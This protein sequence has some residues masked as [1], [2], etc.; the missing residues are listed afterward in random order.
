[1]HRTQ[2]MLEVWQYE[3]LRARA[4]GAG[5]SLSEIVRRAVTAYLT[6][7]EPLSESPLLALEGIGDDGL[8]GRNHDEALYAPTSQS[9]RHRQ[10]KA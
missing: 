2:L 8:G 10:R 9:A 5:V 3:A 4:E 6:P 7:T 1:M